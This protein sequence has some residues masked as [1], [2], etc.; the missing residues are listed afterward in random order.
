MKCNSL[1]MFILFG[2]VAIC[3]ASLAHDGATGIV[4]KRMDAMS[5]IGDQ[6]KA[7]AAILK[8]E[9]TF[10]ASSV[11]TSATIIAGHARNIPE[12]FPEGSL[13]KPSEALPV[14][15]SR[16]EDFTKL[17]SSMEA[18]AVSLAEVANSAQSITDVRDQI[19]AVGKSCKA[20]HAD[21]RQA[22]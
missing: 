16:W 5:D 8:G 12:L 6:M 3:G 11:H 15:W 7:M 19:I 2:T 1:R 17:G 9:Q 22:K 20:C 13:K 21:F 14:V 10:D 4:K 18:S